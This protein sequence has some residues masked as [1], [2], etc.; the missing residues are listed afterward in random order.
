[1]QG[2]AYHHPGTG[3]HNCA[4]G[5]QGG[6][7]IPPAAASA[8]PARRAPPRAASV[9]RRVVRPQPADRGRR[10]LVVVGGG[11]R[12]PLRDRRLGGTGRCRLVSR[13]RI[14]R[15]CGGISGLWLR[16]GAST[17][18]AA[19]A[20][21]GAS[22]AAGSAALTRVASAARSSSAARNS[23]AT[24]SAFA[25]RRGASAAALRLAAAQRRA[26]A[27]LAGPAAR[28]GLDPC[29]SGWVAAVR[30]C[31]QTRH[32]SRPAAAPYWDRHGY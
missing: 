14:T 28:Q 24:R 22:T 16:L 15:R 2:H 31:S 30:R 26:R 3:Q 29:R 17:G 9:G 7:A 13:L 20:G 1:M 8:P 27:R 18:A 32:R 25:V 19:C 21:S 5:D 12:R 10:G 23:A 11:A 4:E 6:S